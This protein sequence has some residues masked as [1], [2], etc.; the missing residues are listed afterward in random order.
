MSRQTD[1]QNLIRTYNRRLQILEEQKAYQG[2]STPPY[3]LMEIEDIKAKLE[4]L[5]ALFKQTKDDPEA[6]ASIDL[7]RELAQLKTKVKP[8]K[9]ETNIGSFVIRDNT[10]SSIKISDAKIVTQPAGDLVGGDKITIGQDKDALNAQDKL[11]AAL[12]EWK[13]ELEAKIATLADLEAYKKDDLKEKVSKF[14]EEAAKGA[15]ANPD[16]LAWL[17][18]TMSSMAPDILEVTVA[19]LQNPFAGVG[20]VLRKINDKIKLE[21]QTQ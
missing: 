9:S 20:L 2:L 4:E 15:A 11:M 7:D 21:R 6:I 10:N 16:Q 18:N 19:I 3:I 14:D 8:E 5:Q 17:L 1:I 13:R 12:A